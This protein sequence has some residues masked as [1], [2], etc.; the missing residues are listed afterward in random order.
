MLYN[1]ALACADDISR[2]TGVFFHD[3]CLHSVWQVSAFCVIKHAPHCKFLLEMTFLLLLFFC[4]LMLRLNGL[5][6]MA[7]CLDWRHC[8]LDIIFVDPFFARQVLSILH[9]SS[10]IFTFVFAT[11]KVL[12]SWRH[13]CYTRGL[14]CI[15]WLRI[16]CFFSPTSEWI[17]LVRSGIRTINGGDVTKD[18]ELRYG[19]LSAHFHAIKKSPCGFIYFEAE[20]SFSFL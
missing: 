16:R 19:H 20:S 3:K 14:S 17:R 12:F 1:S 18:L 4:T 7:G 10:A 13:F 5:R 15:C 2:W 6:I 8:C 11:L 9:I